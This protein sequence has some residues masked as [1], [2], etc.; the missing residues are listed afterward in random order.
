MILEGSLVA[1][2]PVHIYHRAKHKNEHHFILHQLFW[3]AD[4]LLKT[5]NSNKNAVMSNPLCEA[6]F[7][8]LF[9]FFLAYCT[10]TFPQVHQWTVRS[11]DF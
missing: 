11:V 4:R 2:L 8:L 7:S 3:A 6:C 5:E 1:L 10:M 9:F